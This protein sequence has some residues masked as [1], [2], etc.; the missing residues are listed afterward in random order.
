MWVEKLT[1]S[2]KQCTK[3]ALEPANQHNKTNYKLFLTLIKDLSFQPGTY[4]VYRFHNI[5]LGIYK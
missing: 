3:T 4:K 5:L 2:K 1:N